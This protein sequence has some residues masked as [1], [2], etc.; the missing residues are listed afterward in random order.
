[1]S[2]LRIGAEVVYNGGTGSYYGCSDHNV[3]VRGKRYIIIGKRVRAWQTDYNLEGVEGSF[4]SVWFDEVEPQKT[5]LARAEIYHNIIWYIGKRMS[6]VKIQDKEPYFD[7][8]TTSPVQSIQFVHENVCKIET[9]NS[10][11][12]TKIGKRTVG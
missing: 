7:P 3:L 10:V 12:I 11:Y 8:V 6:L 5:Y 2:E 4:N 9:E 1:M